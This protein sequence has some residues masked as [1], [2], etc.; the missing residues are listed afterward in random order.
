MLVKLHYNPQSSGPKIKKKFQIP[1][2]CTTLTWFWGGSVDHA[3]AN[4]KDS[5]MWINPPRMQS[6]SPGS[7]RPRWRLICHDCVLVTSNASSPRIPFFS[8]VFQV[9]LV[10][11]VNQLLT[12]QCFPQYLQPAEPDLWKHGMK[13]AKN[14]VT[15]RIHVWYIYLR[16]V[17]LEGKC[18]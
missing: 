15:H 17:D 16:L 2:T 1:H 7:T 3:E 6:S 14:A 5:I 4:P 13:K 18:R 9:F 11:K 12:A 8:E 10:I